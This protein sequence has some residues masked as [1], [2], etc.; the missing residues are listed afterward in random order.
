VKLQELP[1]ALILGL[2]ASLLAHMV[3][4]GGAHATG[5]VHHE[6]LVSLAFAGAVGF[7]LLLG[8]IG[9]FNARG[10]AEGSVLASHL[11]PLL[12]APATLFAFATFS[13]FA[14]EAV[15][16]QHAQLPVALVLAAL[17]AATLA[18]WKLALVLVR[19][20][21]HVVFELASEPFVKRRPAYLRRF[22]RTARISGARRS[23]RRHARPPPSVMLF[24]IP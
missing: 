16:G 10:L 12:P 2:L 18:I 17:L 9:W 20:I 21:A 14:I 11:R 4:Y 15:E 5:G 24:P 6:A 23:Y 1:G 3:S 13:F 7:G 8:L 19:A 22:N